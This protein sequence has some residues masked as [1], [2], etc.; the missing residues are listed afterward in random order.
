MTITLY[1]VTRSRASRAVWLCLEAGLPFEHVPV[2]QARRLADP[3][4]PD[5]PLNTRSPSFL[6]INP[7]GLVP[8]MQDGDLVL[9]ESF[10]INLYLAKKAGAPI[11]P[12]DLAED[13]QMTMWSF[14]VA[15]EVEPHAMHILFH[16]GYLPEAE[17]EPVK[18]DDA[19]LALAPKFAV[20]DAHLAGRDWLVADRFTVA[21]LNVAEVCRYAGMAPE[22]FAAAPNVKRWYDACQARP[23][24]LEMMRRREAEPA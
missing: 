20:L 6:E 11:G 16:R 23:A 4:A 17:R 15:A 10:A 3:L 12:K 21:D 9:V 22:L 1:G 18:A 13:G 24:F 2:I 19:V 7:N 8:A 5:A 14:W